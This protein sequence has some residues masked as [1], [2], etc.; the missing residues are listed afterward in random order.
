MLFDPSDPVFWVM[1]AFFAFFALLVYYKVPGTVGK[2]LDARAEAIRHELDEARRL[3]DEAQSLLNDYQRKSRQAEE[4]AKSIIEQARRESEA[5][6]AETRK[7]L[8]ESVERRT[9]LADEK[10]ARA[11]RRQSPRFA[12]PRSIAPSRR[13]RRSSR[14]ARPERRR[15]RSSSRASAISTAS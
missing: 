8:T 3:R 14:R 12:L 6:A 10:I 15:M 1:I 7:S 5:L 13:R 4:E 11:K 2:V 9:R